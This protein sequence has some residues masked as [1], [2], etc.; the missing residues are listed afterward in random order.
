MK[1]NDSKQIQQIGEMFTQIPFE[2]TFWAASFKLA[3]KIIPV[4]DP[5]GKNRTLVFKDMNFMRDQ[6]SVTTESCIVG[7]PYFLS[8]EQSAVMQAMFKWTVL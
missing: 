7:E 8:V 3:G 4:F 1:E 5:I 6:I 2:A